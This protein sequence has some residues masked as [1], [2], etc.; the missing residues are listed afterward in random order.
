MVEIPFE[1]DIVLPWWRELSSEE[2]HLV[3]A[4]RS[5]SDVVVREDVNSGISVF[6][7]SWPPFSGGSSYYCQEKEEIT[8]KAGKDGRAIFRLRI[9]ETHVSRRGKKKQTCVEVATELS[10]RLGSTILYTRMR[11]VERGL[12]KRWIPPLGQAIQ[13]RSTLIQDVRRCQ[14]ALYMGWPGD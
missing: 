10:E 13:V 9:R 3:R 6:E 11:L 7:A 1:A 14:K 4:I 12:R 2:N 5:F 8:P